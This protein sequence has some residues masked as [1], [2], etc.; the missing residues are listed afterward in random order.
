[1]STTTTTETD[2]ASA[3][4]KLAYDTKHSDGELEIDDNAIVSE[5]DE[6]GAYVAAWVW[7][8]FDGTRLSKL[9][10]LCDEPL[11]ADGKCDDCEEVAK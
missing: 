5:G 3:I 10:E 2:R 9:C 11:N 1:M 7:V 6:N 8:S 4:R